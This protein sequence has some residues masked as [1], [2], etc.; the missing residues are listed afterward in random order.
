MIADT[1]FLIDLEREQRRGRPGVATTWARNNPSQRLKVAWVT[2]G[3]FLAGFSDDRR[4][5]AEEVLETYTIL[6]A[7]EAVRWNW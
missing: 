6:E 5:A 7:D 4:R 3:E 1:T 2:A